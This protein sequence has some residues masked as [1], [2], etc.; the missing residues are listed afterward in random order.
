MT[1]L[2]MPTLKVYRLHHL[3]YRLCLQGDC[4]SV[5]VTSLTIS[6]MLKDAQ[7]NPEGG[8]YG[9]TTIPFQSCWANYTDLAINSTGGRA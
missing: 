1:A 3:W 7:G 2:I 4:V 9:N 8:L 5:G 6:A